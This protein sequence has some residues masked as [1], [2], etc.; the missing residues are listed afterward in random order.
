VTDVLELV[1]LP[2]PALR[3]LA[4]GDLPGAS[5]VVGLEVPAAL[6]GDFVPWSVFV[7]RRALPGSEGWTIQLVVEDGVVVGHGGFHEPPDDDGVVELG[8]TVVPRARGRGVAT[9]VVGLLLD[10]ARAAEQVRVVRGCTAPQNLAS[11]AVLRHHG[12]VLVGEELDDV[13]G[14]EL[15]HELAVG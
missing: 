11:Q 3:C 5:R 14:L 6:L 12:F 13:D 15:V 2:V 4:D 7:D 10:R 8:Y 9:A 1:D